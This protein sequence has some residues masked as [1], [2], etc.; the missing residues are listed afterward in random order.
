MPELTFT[1]CVLQSFSRST[2]G[3]VAKF[4]AALTTAVCKE[5]DWEEIPDF[6]TGA[7]PEGDLAATEAELTPSDKELEPMVSGWR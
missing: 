7:T 6:L 3:G 1:A 4:S 2:S 5:M